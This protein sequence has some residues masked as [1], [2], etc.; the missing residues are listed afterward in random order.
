MARDNFFKK[1]KTEKTDCKV[2][3]SNK[4]MLVGK[5]TDYDDECVVVDQCLIFY[6]QII[7]IVPA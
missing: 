2:F 6:E 4:T 3:L 1:L 5:I 7:S